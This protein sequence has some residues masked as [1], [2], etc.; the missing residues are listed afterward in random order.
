MQC[1]HV[2]VKQEMAKNRLSRLSALEIRT[3]MAGT[4][5][6]E[7]TAFIRHVLE[8]ESCK[9]KCF[10][11]DGPEERCR[12]PR[13]WKLEGQASIEQDLRNLKTSAIKGV[14]QERSKPVTSSYHR[15]R[16]F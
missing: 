1:I 7:M 14:Y 12:K 11:L 8:N 6:H 9:L 13:R 5:N 3:G 15:V 10:I 2:A 16:T 4:I